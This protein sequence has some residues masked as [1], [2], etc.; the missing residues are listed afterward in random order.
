MATKH[1]SAQPSL[2]IDE[3]GSRG[4]LHRIRPHGA[5]YRIAVQTRSVDADR[6]LHAVLVNERAQRLEPHRR[7][8]FEDRVQ[9]DD[10][11]RRGLE[12]F[13]DSLGLRYGVCH[14]AGAKHLE[15]VQEHHPPPKTLKLKGLRRIEPGRRLPCG[16]GSEL[17]HSRSSSVTE[18]P[19]T[20]AV[21]YVCPWIALVT[22]MYWLLASG[23]ARGAGPRPPSS[24]RTRAAASCQEG[25]FPSP[26]YQMVQNDPSTSQCPEALAA[27]AAPVAATVASVV[28]C[29][30]S[31]R[32]LQ[33]CAEDHRRPSALLPACPG[34][35]F[36]CRRDLEAGDARRSPDK[37]MKLMVTFDAH[38]L[39][40]RH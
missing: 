15:G 29:K 5:G 9:S 33:L 1:L 12:E 11:H 14:A 26:R 20:A 8:V 27:I 24:E 35:G 3:E 10:R 30:W 2:R 38:R 7:M 16:R 19:A 21:P 39:S 13:G 25:A 4:A 18:E 37:P 36:R 28:G 32:I 23:R 31:V 22:F 34:G 40:A 17:H 6:E